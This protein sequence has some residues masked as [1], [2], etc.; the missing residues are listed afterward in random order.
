A[1]LDALLGAWGPPWASVNWE[2]WN[3]IGGPIGGTTTLGQQQNELMLS[4]GEVLDTLERVLALRG[5]PRLAV[6]TGDLGRRMQQW[7]DVM[8]AGPAAGAHARP[9]SGVAY[10][11]PENPME[12]RIAEIWQELLGVDRVGM[13]DDF[14]LLGGN[15]LAGLQI[16]SKMRAEFDVE[17]PLKAFFEART[18]AGMAAEIVRE[19]EKAEFEKQRLEEILAEI[20]AL[21]LD[22]VKA[23]LAE[24]EA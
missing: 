21:S 23:H 10:R 4:P 13:D 16:L 14:F 17:L 5:Q 3:A 7:S 15:S 22:E 12:A 8:H 20:E 11:A 9:D 24:E 6:A 2:V 19:K 1:A 18:V